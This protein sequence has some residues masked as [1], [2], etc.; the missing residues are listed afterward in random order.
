MKSHWKNLKLYIRNNSILF[1]CAL[2][3]FTI[4]CND[5]TKQGND[6]SN[7]GQPQDEMEVDTTESASY[8]STEQ[9]AGN[10]DADTS[11]KANSPSDSVR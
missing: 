8:G 1:I 7:I 3:L 11:G 9:S 4:A 5:T 6:A 10:V 2:S